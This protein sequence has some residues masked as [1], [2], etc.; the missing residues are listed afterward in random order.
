[1]TRAPTVTHAPTS[2][3]EYDGLPPQSV[4]AG[5]TARI[6]NRRDCIILLIVLTVVA[7]LIVL[8]ARRERKFASS[9]IKFNISKA[10][11][12]GPFLFF[13]VLDA[14]FDGLFV[15]FRYVGKDMLYFYVGLFL[16]IIRG[17]TVLIMSRWLHTK[18]GQQANRKVIDLKLLKAGN[19][20]YGSVLV[21]TVTH[22]PWLIALLPWFDTIGVRSFLGVP[23]SQLFLR[24]VAVSS[25]NSICQIILKISFLL[26]Q[27]PDL[28]TE[29]GIITNFVVLIFTLWGFLKALPI[30]ANK[31]ADS[32]QRTTTKNISSS[33]HDDSI[34]TLQLDDDT[35]Q[36]IQE[37]SHSSAM[38]PKVR[39]DPQDPTEK[40]MISMKIDFLPDD[41]S[42]QSGIVLDPFTPQSQQGTPSPHVRKHIIQ[43]S[44]ESPSSSS[45]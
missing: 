12:L 26:D 2:I 45:L 28:G 29:L 34:P 19:L 18:K 10:G 17:L 9:V 30:L 43:F 15:C 25:I 8:A 11:L 1:M 20:V 37:K 23:K 42:E 35:F 40:E 31:G 38:T 44:P 36:I 14:G 21:V 24:F 16:V 33:E 4:R 7:W 3:D 22:S 13:V 32:M 27:T 6:K 5:L 41:E 39:H